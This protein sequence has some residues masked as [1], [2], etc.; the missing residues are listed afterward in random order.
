MKFNNWSLC[1]ISK[2]LSDNGNNFKTM[3]LK[4]FNKQ[5][6]KDALSELC[7]R[8]LHNFKN[9]EKTI[10]F[11][12]LNNIAGYRLSSSLCPIITHDSVNMQICDL[13]NFAD[14]QDVCSR[15]KNLLKIQPIKISAH[16][17]EYISLSTSDENILKNTFRD[18]NQHGEIFDLL[19]LPLD[20]SAPMNI[21]VRK[22]GNVSDIASSVMR[23]YERL[24]D[25]VRKRLVFE[26]NDN[27]NG[28]WSVRNL[29]KHFHK[30]YSI[31]V[32]FDTL[33]HYILPDGLSE[34]DAFDL[35]YSSWGSYTPVFHYSEGIEEN[36]V[37]TRKHRD[38]PTN[39]P[40]SYDCN[41]FWDIEL[42]FKDLAIFEL[43][44]LKE[45][46]SPIY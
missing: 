9:T 13:P 3:T 18:L 1:C 35:A 2:T 5:S 38:M 21:H 17:S 34:R 6:P 24:S 33:H 29:F 28:T 23:N 36:G 44:R 26:N 7:S 25:S 15:I 46:N 32:T 42:K 37:I 27:K 16:P 45:L 22:D 19:G 41:V 39:I 20:Y 14:I 43:R 8:I 11:C 12:Q 30:T 40:Y 10:R 4:Q 31:P